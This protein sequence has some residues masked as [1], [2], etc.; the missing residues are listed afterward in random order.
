[1]PAQIA[2][3][4]IRPRTDFIVWLKSEQLFKPP[5]T[6]AAQWLTEC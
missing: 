1:M 5:L 6:H 4:W 3:N 2:L